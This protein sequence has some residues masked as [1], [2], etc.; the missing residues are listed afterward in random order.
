ML[1]SNANIHKNLFDSIFSQ[2]KG[3]IGMFLRIHM[4]FLRT[5]IYIP[6]IQKK[7]EKIHYEQFFKRNMLILY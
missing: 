1:I 4:R 2:V 5:Y 3:D 7:N 6:F